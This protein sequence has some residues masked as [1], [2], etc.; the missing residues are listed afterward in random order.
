[1]K[2]NRPSAGRISPTNVRIAVGNEA[3]DD[4]RRLIEAMASETM[5][6]IACLDV[7]QRVEPARLPMADA[8]RD[9]ECLVPIW[10]AVQPVF[11]SIVDGAG[12]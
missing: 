2:E 10:T 9:R 3:E 8:D 5:T 1:M 4:G 11:L 6:K 7:V 12:G